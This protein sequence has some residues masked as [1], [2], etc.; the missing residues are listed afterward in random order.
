M[1]AS[2]AWH[3]ATEPNPSSH[4]SP[5]AEAAT[6]GDQRGPVPAHGRDASARSTTH[7]LMIPSTLGTMGYLGMVKNSC[8]SVI[9]CYCATLYEFKLSAGVCLYC[10]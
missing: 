8:G 3:I 9:L 5:E 10:F 6:G 2:A 1:R 4:D 7:I